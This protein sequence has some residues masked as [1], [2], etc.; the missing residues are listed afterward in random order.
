MNRKITQYKIKDEIIF[1]DNKDLSLDAVERMKYY[2]A[3]AHG[4]TPD[5]VEVEAID[6]VIELSDIDVTN[7]GLFSWSD[8]EY[9]IY[10]GIM[11]NLVEGSDEHLDAINNGS[12]ENYLIF[13]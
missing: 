8:V 2:I 13:N 1:E 9:K 12:V 10:S 7:D 5:D 3:E 6:S 4:C 11:L